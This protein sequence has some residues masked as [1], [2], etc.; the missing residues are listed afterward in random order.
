[1]PVPTPEQ[2]NAYEAAPAQVA[3]AIANL[4]EAQMHFIRAEGDWSVHEVII[5]LADSEVF[6]YERMRKT[7]A[8]DNPT[9]DVYDEN[10]WAMNLSYR[11]QD[12]NLAIVL[13]TALRHSSAALLRML[14]PE[15]WERTCMHPERGEM[16]LYETFN[17]F[18]E[19]GKIHL[20]QIEQL[21]CS[22]G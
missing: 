14:P 10:A 7:M 9:V 12:R 2:L 11:T 1:M 13:F 5:H 20:E 8:E 3:A 16:S 4:S 17:T 18:L 19:H 6:G 15:A 21:K 22:M